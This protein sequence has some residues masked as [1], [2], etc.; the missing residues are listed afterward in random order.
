MRKYI[1]SVCAVMMVSQLAYAETA[2]DVMKKIGEIA[3]K[4]KTMQYKMKQ[5]GTI[6]QPGMEMKTITNG[7]FK[8]MRKGEMMLMRADMNTSMD[9]AMMKMKSD[10]LMVTDEKYTWMY[11]DSVTEAMGQKTPQKM[12]MKNKIDKKMTD[13][14]S[15][16]Q[17][18]N[19]DMKLLPEESVDGKPAWV[20]EMTPKNPAQK[21]QSPRT[22]SWYE[23]K[24]GLP[25]KTVSYGPEGKPVSTTTF[26]DHKVD[27][28]LSE[29]LFKF[30]P[31]AGVQVMDLTKQG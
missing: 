1:F 26:S 8:Y 18:E 13:P 16:A 4:H 21:A 14:T 24:S 29:D 30:E 20:L 2:E 15:M 5:E 6:K 28:K 9:S 7:D 31:P 19:F 27:E 23:K 17:Y 12:V 3:K 10:S 11:T 25:L 22:V